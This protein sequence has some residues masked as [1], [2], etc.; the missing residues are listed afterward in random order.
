MGIFKKRLPA[1]RQLVYLFLLC[2]FLS[3][4]WALYNAT[5]EFPAWLLRLSLGEIVAVVSYTMVYAL[6]DALLMFVGLVLASMILPGRWLRDHFLAAGSVVALVTAVWLII[7]NFY[8][9]IF[10]ERSVT[11]LGLWGGSYLIVLAL[12]YLWVLR[13]DKARAAV[14]RFVERLALLSGVY[15]VITAI[16]I[17]VIL[18]RNIWGA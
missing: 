18:V 11:L 16:S 15:L 6:L 14:A 13:S 2:A 5:Q 12:L 8:P 1:K 4:A 10:E 3:N 7:F 17:I 9:A